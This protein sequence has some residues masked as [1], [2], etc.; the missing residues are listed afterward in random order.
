MDR[1]LKALTYLKRNHP[2]YASIQ[3]DP[4]FRFKFG[5]DVLFEKSG[6]SQADA[7]N[8]IRR[9]PIQGS[10]L[11]EEVSR[12]QALMPVNQPTGNS[13]LPAQQFQLQRIKAQPFN[14][15]VPNLDLIAFTDLFPNGN[16]GFN[17]ERA[18]KLSASQYIRAVLLNEYRGIA[19]SM[20]W[21]C[22][23][24]RSKNST[25]DISMPRSSIPVV[26]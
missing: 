7:D 19:L 9:Q 13:R 26:P 5:E 24:V 6:A 17:A 1:V 4:N 22:Y 20:H 18:K 11:L 16:G 10:I 2:E 21:T 25:S 15:D 23:H 3:L 14:K 12:V 8:L